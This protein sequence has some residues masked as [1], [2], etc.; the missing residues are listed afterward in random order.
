MYVI[1]NDELANRPWAEHGDRIRC[2]S[3]RAIHALEA[4]ASL[5]FYQCGTQHFLAGVDN[6]LGEGLETIVDEADAS[7]ADWAIDR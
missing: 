7:H 3:C 5:L 6:R 4:V 1:G 2:P